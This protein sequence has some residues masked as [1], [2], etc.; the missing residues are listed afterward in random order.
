VDANN[1]ARISE[2]KGG[3]FGKPWQEAVLEFWFHDDTS[4][5]KDARGYSPS[6]TTQ[7]H[8]H[9]QLESQPSPQSPENGQHQQYHRY[10]ESSEIVC[11]SEDTETTE[12]AEKL[13]GINILPDQ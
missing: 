11:W 8:H 10:F 9:Q 4:K 6:L 1:L 7:A 3:K 12:I 5:I 13:S 2:G